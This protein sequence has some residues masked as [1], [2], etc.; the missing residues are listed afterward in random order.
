MIL[1]PCQ[2]GTD[3]SKVACCVLDGYLPPTAVVSVCLTVS[4]SFFL[5][6]HTIHTTTSLQQQTHRESSG[7]CKT[8]LATNLLLGLDWL[9]L[10][11]LDTALLSCMRQCCPTCSYSM[12]FS[13]HNPVAAA[14][15]LVL[16]FAGAGHVRVQLQGHV[17]S[18]QG[19][20]WISDSN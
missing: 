4:N 10:C 1:T 6:L 7:P 20:S 8:H 11:G 16:W 19:E 12:Q 5:M 18:R 9:Q 15:S 3:C 13:Q 2:C 14:D 17:Q